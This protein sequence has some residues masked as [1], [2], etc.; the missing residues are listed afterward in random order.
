MSSV[1]VALFALTAANG[2][3]LQAGDPSTQA[4]NAYTACLRQFMQRSLN[5]RMSV[6]DFRSGLPQQCTTQEQAFR[7]TLIRRE[8]SFRTPRSEA[9][10]MATMEVEDARSNFIQLFENSSQPS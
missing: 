9:E 4:R 6:A 5:D 2:A 3:A 8:V 7:D 1:L 10:E